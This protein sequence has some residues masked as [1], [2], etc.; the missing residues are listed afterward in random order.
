MFVLSL[1]EFYEKWILIKNIEVVLCWSNH[2]HNCIEEQREQNVARYIN[3]QNTKKT[4][5][6][7]YN[8]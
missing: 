2:F 3:E 8:N 6:I 4:M 1:G 5:Y 7:M